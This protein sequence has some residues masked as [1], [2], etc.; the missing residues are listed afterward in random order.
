MKYRKA[1][2]LALPIAGL[3]AC[4]GTMGEPTVA[5]PTTV[6]VTTT[7]VAPTTTV[8]VTTTKAP[9]TTR[10][11]QFNEVSVVEGSIQKGSR[12]GPFWT[13]VLKAENHSSKV[14]DYSIEHACYSAGVQMDTGFAK[15]V[16]V[17]PGKSGMVSTVCS[18]APEVVDE[19]RIIS[20]ERDSTVGR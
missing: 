4:G 19:V 16:A 11:S 20:V 5:P 7:T 12:L 1:Y 18:S 2:L 3:A 9:T 13:F 17:E 14:S 15:I 6:K 10:I 8:K